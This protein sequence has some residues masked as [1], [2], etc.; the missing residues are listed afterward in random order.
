[1]TI[2][3]NRTFG[4]FIFVWRLGFVILVFKYCNDI[5]AQLG[6]IRLEILEIPFTV[7]QL[8]LENIVDAFIY[9]HFS[10]KLR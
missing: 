5:P 7:R 2:I 10:S 9:S 6:G 8:D 1:M 3:F 4:Y